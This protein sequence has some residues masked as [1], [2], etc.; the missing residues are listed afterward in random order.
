MITPIQSLPRSIDAEKAVL[1]IALEDSA[2]YVPKLEQ[3]W[4]YLPAHQTIAK[5]LRETAAQNSGNADMTLLLTWLQ[6]NDKLE[7]VGGAGAIADIATDGAMPSIWDDYASVLSDKAKRRTMI[8]V[9]DNTKHR[10]QHDTGKADDIL[11][12]AE[13]SLFAIGEAGKTEQ[14]YHIREALL[15]TQDVLEAAMKRG[16]GVL[17]GLSTG[18]PR[19][20]ELCH[21][22]CPGCVYVLGGRTSAGKTALAVNLVDAIAIEQQKQTLVFALEMDDV[23]WS[24]RLL[25]KRSDV[26]LSKI[27]RADM[28]QERLVKLMGATQPIAAAPL[29]IDVCPGSTIERI[30]S[31]SRK[32]K[33][34]NGLDLVVIDYY[35][36]LRTEMPGSFREKLVHISH[37]VQAMAADLQ[38]PVLMLAQ[39][40]RG[41]VGKRPQVSDISESDAPAQDADVVWLL[42]REDDE[43][44]DTFGATVN[45]L[46]D[47]GRYCGTGKVETTFYGSTQ[48][49]TE[50]KA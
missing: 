50:H 13:A 4:F 11:E 26:F 21:G 18:M 19:L 20:D 44:P 30:V 31:K 34:T 3:E 37:T 23:G 35:Q 16:K 29:N 42:E 49:F 25:S 39:L 43:A 6:D 24:Q 40:N 41:A 46:Q 48:T 7:S 14:T 38:V 9:C 5:G 32:W 2:E 8:A 33:R 17:P 47:K 45:I 28:N 22:L 1:A 15:R 27:I 36:L 12:S 10:A